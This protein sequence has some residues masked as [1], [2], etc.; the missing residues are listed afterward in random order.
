VMP[1]PKATIITGKIDAII[2]LSLR[3]KEPAADSVGA[4]ISLPS[5]EENRI[6]AN[7]NRIEFGPEALC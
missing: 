2:F 6:V 1:A 4:A 5:G 3:N 7:L